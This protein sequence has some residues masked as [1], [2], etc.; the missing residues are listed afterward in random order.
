MD[1]TSIT[2]ASAT[3]SF[4]VVCCFWNQR[5]KVGNDPVVGLMSGWRLPLSNA[6]GNDI[7]E[8]LADHEDRLWMRPLDKLC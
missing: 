7:I 8:K 3:G 6:E 2:S 4:E 1:L 5:R